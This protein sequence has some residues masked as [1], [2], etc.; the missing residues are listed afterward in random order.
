M[1]EMQGR[2]SG[3][4]PMQ[5]QSMLVMMPDGTY[6]QVQMMQLPSSGGLMPMPSSLASSAQGLGGGGGAV[7]G[8]SVGQAALAEAAAA[9]VLLEGGLYGGHTMAEIPMAV[10]QY[11]G[12]DEIVL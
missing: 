8:S 1:T 2:P 7:G 6:Q 10:A 4:V 3:L 5:G 9:P 12:K 11:R